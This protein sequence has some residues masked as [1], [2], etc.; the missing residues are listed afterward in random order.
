LS[1]TFDFPFRR[2]LEISLGYV[3]SSSICY[4]YGEHIYT[5][6]SLF[7][8]TRTPFFPPPTRRRLA[9]GNCRRCSSDLDTRTRF[10]LNM[11]TFPFYL[12]LFHRFIEDVHFSK[13]QALAFIENKFL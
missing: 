6:V 1:P 12:S 11:N 8:L 5:Y 7:R 10:I 4:I 13:F 3:L 2:T 9:N